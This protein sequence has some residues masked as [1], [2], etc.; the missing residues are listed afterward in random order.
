MDMNICSNRGGIVIFFLYFFCSI[1]CFADA[2]E[3]IYEQSTE[4]GIWNTI[5]VQGIKPSARCSHSMVSYNGKYYITCGFYGNSDIW[6]LDITNNTPTFTKIYTPH[7]NDELKHAM[8]HTT[9]V[10]NEK[11]YVLFGN[12][13]DGTG[14]PDSIYSYDFRETTDK[15]WKREYEPELPSSPNYF[16]PRSDFATAVIGE[17]IYVFGGI[18]NSGDLI[19]GNQVFGYFSYSSTTQNLIF[20]PL[21][22]NQNKPEARSGHSMI[23]INNTLYLFGGSDIVT[24]T[25]IFKDLLEI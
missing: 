15:K 21:P 1:F 16:E 12:M 9:L 24:R 14:Y 5:E 8:R 7:S 23:S 10:W 3:G 6:E 25:K 2:G 17:Q 22:L 18:N 20:H 11:L 13:Q 19:E 4:L